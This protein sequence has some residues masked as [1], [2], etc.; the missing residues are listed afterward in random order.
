MNN[1]I[2]NIK[3]HYPVSDSSI[4]LLTSHCT[5]WQFPAKHILIQE[6]SIRNTQ[7]L[8]REFLSK[9]ELIYSL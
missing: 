6:G 9:T 8:W 4:K 2:N 5:P 7:G 1:I 3:K